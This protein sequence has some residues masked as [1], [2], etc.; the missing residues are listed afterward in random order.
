MEH[1]AERAPTR[2]MSSELPLLF[3]AGT[4]SLF[5]LLGDR[6]LADLSNP[7]WLM[8]MFAWLFLTTLWA[9][10]A[11]VRHADALAILLG[12]PYGTLVLT[13]SVICVE[14]S[15][16]SAV[17]LHGR[18]NPTMARDAMFAVIMIV[19]NGMVGLALLAG[20][21][22]HREQHYNLQGANSYLA[23]LIP[24]A[25]LSLVLPVYTVTTPDPSLSPFQ[26][27]FL[28]IISLALYSA[29]LA[30]QTV[31]H[32]QYFIDPDD[33]VEPPGSLPHGAAPPR[34]PAVRVLLLLA[35]LIPVVLLAE[36]LALPID[37][38]VETLGA[39]QAL[40]GLVVAAVVVTPEAT[41][42]I[43]A[44][45]ANHL[46]RSVNISLGSVLATIGLTVPAVLSIG[47]ISGRKIELGLPPTDVVMLMLTLMVSI[48]TFSSARSNVLQ[49][50]VHLLLFL[51]Y[52]MLV[53][54]P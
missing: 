22:R 51:A 9:A 15:M 25:V 48:V 10:L 11:A 52:I 16:I 43:R 46:Q 39:P 54:Q 28:I 40:A 26:T 1:E 31:R 12:E 38:V 29:F 2:H 44:A 32:S 21:W 49:G 30:I 17:M 5:V 19:L 47:L 35:Y 8:L 36:K 3:V 50:L 18:N 14:V 13:L 34:H 41:G 37:Y 4:A 20:G 33:V 6:W 53:F 7:F 45:L 27:V 24:L 42:A 23:V